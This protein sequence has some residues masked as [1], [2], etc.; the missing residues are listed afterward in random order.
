[1]SK[2]V[3]EVTIAKRKMGAMHPP[4]IVAE[5]SGNHLRDKNRAKLLF[6]EA[7]RA[8]VDAIKIQTYTPDS[9]AIEISPEKIASK[10]QWKEAWGWNTG[11][12]YNLYK[13]VY[14]PQGDF[15]EYLF[16]LGDEFDLTVFSTPFSVEDAI[17]LAERFD[18]PAYKVGALEYNFFPML[19]VIA[20]TKKPIILN[21][22]IATIDKIEVTLEFLKKAGSGPVILV[23]GPKIYHADSAK[24]FML[25]RL[26]ALQSKFA[27][28]NVLGLSD[29]FLRGVYNGTYYQGHEFSV[30]GILQYGASFIEKHFCGCRSGLPGGPGGDVDGTSSIVTEEMQALVYWARQAHKKAMDG[31]LSPEVE[32][33]LQLIERKAA[34]G[35]GE[36]MFGPTQ[37]E[38]ETHEAGATRYIYARKDLPA[39]KALQQGDIHFSR[40]IHHA[41]PEAKIKTFLPT[42]TVSQVLGNRLKHALEKGDPIFAESLITPID[43]KI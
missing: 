43:L 28:T 8:G 38:I 17:Y 11:D 22:C 27:K 31:K 30:A 25:G 39:D 34:Y 23:T 6:S 16:A 42:S 26:H 12:I 37:A 41:H 19:E 35:Y 1:M 32:M 3:P 13:Q 15:T 18:P 40:A 20:K 33:E 7:K 10:P 36:K 29:H 24:N 14:T 21:V 2:D 5:I 9:L 4:Y